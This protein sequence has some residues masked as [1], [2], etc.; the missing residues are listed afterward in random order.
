MRR[1]RK[2]PN[3]RLLQ[4]EG[5]G[6]PLSKENTFPLDTTVG[7]CLGRCVGPRGG[8]LSYERGTPVRWNQSFPNAELRQV[9]KAQPGDIGLLSRFSVDVSVVDNLFKLPVELRAWGS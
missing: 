7:L 3:S 1:A 9:R 8:V 2:R 6:V 5:T 4:G